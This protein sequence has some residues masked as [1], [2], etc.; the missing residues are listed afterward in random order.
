MSYA[1][2]RL[3][4]NG[5]GWIGKTFDLGGRE[6]E[7][8]AFLAESF[9]VDG[10][11][12]APAVAWSEIDMPEPRVDAEAEAELHALLGAERTRKDPY[13]RVFHALGK[14]YHDLLRVRAGRLPD[15]P[16]L[17]VYPE[18]E[19]DIEG[20]FALAT[21]HRWAIVPFGGGSSVVG[22][23]EAK[24]S[25]NQTAIVCVDT[26]RMCKFLSLDENARLA[27]AEAG[28]YGP[29]LERQLQE[30]GY[31]LRHYPQSFESVAATRPASP[32]PPRAS[33][34]PV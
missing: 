23:V 34:P 21:K 13:E 15:L 32:M 14:S 7:L 18:S 28:V 6:Q 30:R 17:V 9:G 8:L 11:T 16:D 25:A 5:W 29:E 24:R 22:G 31:T 20:I 10:F 19:A 12:P 27:T 2:D 3:K 26:T 4:F 33:A 1:R